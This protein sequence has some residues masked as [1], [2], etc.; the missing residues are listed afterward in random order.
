MCLSNV[1]LECLLLI[2]SDLELHNKASFLFDISKCK[3]I[4]EQDQH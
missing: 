2:V 3:Q 1:A 4:K